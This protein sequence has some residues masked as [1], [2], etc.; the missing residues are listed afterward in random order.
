M[1]KLL[2]SSVTHF[3]DHSNMVICSETFLIITDLL[4]NIVMKTMTAFSSGFLESSEYNVQ[5][6]W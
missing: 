4:L 2:F 6:E 1:E 5:T 3:R